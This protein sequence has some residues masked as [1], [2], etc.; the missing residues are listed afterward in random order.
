M[1]SNTHHFA[2]T[3]LGDVPAAELG[4]CYCHEH[5][6]ISP[7]LATRLDPDLRIDDPDIMASELS[8]FTRLGG[9]T[10]VDMMPPGAGRE[11][12][13]LIALAQCCH[14]NVIATTGFHR[15]RYYD[16]GH[17]LY[18]YSVEQIVDLFTSEITQG[19]DRFG[20]RGPIVDRLNARAGV[21]K[22]ATDYYRWTAQPETWFTAVGLAYLRTL[23]P[24]STHTEHG[25][26]AF[27]QV[28]KLTENP[29]PGFHNELAATGVFLE[30]DG[31]SRLKYHPDSAIIS[32]IAQAADRG[33]D[34]QILRGSDFARRSYLPSY[35][36]GPGLGYLLG[37][38][39]ARLQREGLGHLEQRLFVDNPAQAFCFVPAPKVTAPADAGTR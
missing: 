2:R 39:A 32:L 14:V 10:L 12:T 21:I 3:V 11:A 23:A 30:Y 37:S 22:A 15:E 36:G 27:Q 26:L 24:I 28:A 19:M 6:L 34:R 9:K 17:W 1:T 16:E 38:F 25:A 4:R 31:P 33:Y 29:D 7:S 8:T 18:Q 35:G 13:G 5:L 20:Y